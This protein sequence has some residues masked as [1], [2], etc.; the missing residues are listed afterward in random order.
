MALHAVADITRRNAVLKRILTFVMAALAASICILWG[1]AAQAYVINDFLYGQEWM[2]GLKK[3]PA[4]NVIW[5]G[6]FI[7]S[8]VQINGHGARVVI[9]TPQGA[10]KRVAVVMPDALDL[11]HFVDVPG[12][13]YLDGISFSKMAF[14]VVP[15]SVNLPSIDTSTFPPQVQSHLPLGTISLTPGTQIRGEVDLAG[16]GALKGVLDAMGIQKTKHD[17]YAGFGPMMIFDSPQTGLDQFKKSVLDKMTATVYLPKL[18]LPGLS[19]VATV[20]NNTLQFG[21]DGGNVWMKNRGE[22][23]VTVGSETV[24]FDF[25]VNFLHDG[26]KTFV[27][28]L[29]DEAP[30]SAIELDLLKPVTVSNISVVMDNTYGFWRRLIS[31]DA[32]ING[33][34][35][36]ITYVNN[37]KD[38]KSMYV[39]A[40][41]TLTDVIGG[42]VS[43]PGLDDV[44]LDMA[45]MWSDHWMLKAKLHGHEVNVVAFKRDGDAKHTVSVQFG[46]V[47]P[48]ALIPGAESTPLKEV[49]FGGLNLLYSPRQT[50]EAARGA[51]GIPTE[52]APWLANGGPNAKIRPGL[53]LYANFHIDDGGQIASLLGHVGVTARDL[54]FDGAVSTAVFK[55][56]RTS[57]SVKKE[58]L[59]AL[60]LKIPIGVN[61][62]GLPKGV[63]FQHTYLTVKGKGGMALDIAGTLDVTVGQEKVD[64][65]FDVDVQKKNGKSIVKMTANEVP[66]SQLSI[67]L[68][69][70]FTLTDLSFEMD[71]AQGFWK[72]SLHGDAAI[73]NKTVDITYSNNQW[74]WSYL[75]VKSDLT[76]AEAFQSPGLPGLDDVTLN[77]LMFTPSFMSAELTV[78]GFSSKLTVTGTPERN[79]NH[80]IFWQPTPK[81]GAAAKIS[82]AH[83]I[84][85]ADD[86][87]LKDV[88]LTDLVVVYA[89]GGDTNVARNWLPAWVGDGLNQATGGEET[90][91]SKGINV[92]GK[93][94]AHPQGE[95]KDLLSKAGITDLSHRLSGRFSPKAF[96]PNTEA[97]KDALW[98]A[99][100]INVALPTPTIAEAKDLSFKDGRLRIRGKLPDGSR[101]LDVGISGNVTWDAGVDQHDFYV[102]ISYDKSHGDSDIKV[103]GHSDQPWSDPLGIPG[104][105]LDT[106]TFD[107]QREKQSDGSKEYII[108][109]AG[110]TDIGR[111]KR[112]TAKIGLDK[113]K[114]S[115]GVKSTEAWLEIKDNI[116]LSEM[117]GFGDVLHGDKFTL[118]ELKISP[119]GLEADST[120]NGETIDLYIF[121]VGKHGSTAN[122]G[123]T[124]ALSVKDFN[125]TDVIPGIS[126]T[127][128]KHFGFPYAAVIFSKNGINARYENMG[129]IA[130]DAFKEVFTS[131][132]E[133]L[134]IAE[135]VSFVAGFHPDN[136]GAMA[137]GVRGI[138]VHD[139][140]LIMGQ[141]QGLYGGE[142]PMIRLEGILGASGKAH[143]MPAFMS[144]AQ[145]AELDFFITL[146]ESGETFDF[147]LGLAVGLN[148]KI[149]GSPLLFD[150]KVK[151]QIMDEGFGVDVLAQMQGEWHKPFGIPFSLS[152]IGMEAGTQEDGAIKVGFTGGT[153]ISGDQFTMAG[154]AEFLPEAL[155]LPQTFAFK[156]T[157]DEIDLAFLDD[158]AFMMAQQAA[159][160]AAVRLPI[161]K[162]PTPKLKEV[163]FAFATPGSEDPDLGLVSE[164]FAMAGTFNFF[165]QDLGTAQVAIG[166]A[167][168]IKIKGSIKDFD[169]GPISAKNNSL[170]IEVSYTA[171]PKFHIDSHVDILG[172]TETVKLDFKKTGMDFD[173]AFGLGPDFQGDMNLALTGVNLSAKSPSFKNA[174]FFISGAFDAKIADFI[175]SNMKDLANDLKTDLNAKYEE[176]KKKVA[177]AKATVDS[178]NTQINH[179][180]AV[181]RAERQ[182]VERKLDA[183]QSRVDSLNGD[184]AH[185][186]SEYH[187]C[188]WYH[189]WCKPEW[190]ITIAGE[191]A[192]LYIATGVLDAV[193]SLVKHIPLD[194]DPRIWPLIAAKDTA[195][196]ALDAAEKS[197]EGLEDIDDAIASVLDKVADALGNGLNIN[198]ATFEGSLTGVIENDEPVDLG[199][200]VSLFGGRFADTFAF[201]MKD[202]AYNAE[203]LAMMGLYGLDHL[204]QHELDKLPAAMRHQLIGTLAGR[205]HDAQTAMKTELAKYQKDFTKY[206]KTAGTIQ[207]A[208][209]AAAKTFAETLLTSKVSLLDKEPPSRKL[210]GAVIEIAHSG[211]CVYDDDYK[212]LT[213]FPCEHP[214]KAGYQPYNGDSSG[215]LAKQK[216][217]T[218]TVM[219]K[220]KDS[221]YVTILMG[222]KCLALNGAF[223]TEEV[224][225][226]NGMSGFRQVLQPTGASFD[227]CQAG[228]TVQHWKIL[229]HGDRYTQI[230]NRASDLC[231]AFDSWVGAPLNG[232]V[233]FAPCTGGDTQVFRVVNE[234]PQAYYKVGTVFKHLASN[235]CLTVD[236]SLTQEQL[237]NYGTASASFKSC[238]GKPNQIFD[239]MTDYLGRRKFIHKASG[240]CLGFDWR[241]SEARVR[242]CSND[243]GMFFNPLLGPGGAA[244]QAGGWDDTGALRNACLKLSDDGMELSQCAFAPEQMFVLPTSW[245]VGAN[246]KKVQNGSGLTGS[247]NAAFTMAERKKAALTKA[248]TDRDALFKALDAQADEMDRGVPGCLSPGKDCYVKRKPPQ[249]GSPVYD[250]FW[251]KDWRGNNAFYYADPAIK[252]HSDIS[253]ELKALADDLT[254]DRL[255]QVQ[256][257]G[258]GNLKKEPKWYVCRTGVWRG[259]QSWLEGSSNIRVGYVDNRKCVVMDEDSLGVMTYQRADEY[260]VLASGGGLQWIRSG[261]GY[262][263]E[264]ALQLGEIHSQ[265]WGGANTFVYSC[266]ALVNRKTVLGFTVDGKACWTK[267]PFGFGSSSDMSAMPNFEVLSVD[268]SVKLPP[269]PAPPKP[270]LPPGQSLQPGETEKEVCKVNGWFGKKCKECVMTQWGA[271]DYCWSKDDPNNYSMGE[272]GW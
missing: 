31:G 125:I 144:F 162:I 192:A 10:P 111:H 251:T 149:T 204:I 64:F 18:S 80:L 105:T 116:D 108:K 57:A 52:V 233:S 201:K 44:E 132:G 42:G 212:G 82:P 8:R 191:K 14:I 156:A 167:T 214:H 231:L 60:D 175:D 256:K 140:L 15:P 228:N 262:L 154:D 222:G 158:V 104:F 189:P 218:G 68:L 16:N 163:M 229:D 271:Y 75:D 173:V 138:G 194:F 98:D 188:H 142:T 199:L 4:T 161:D 249:S 40:K 210:N 126:S 2:P 3:L 265:N 245:N 202:M 117:P 71:N 145:S 76:L 143:N 28:L 224:S 12:G 198:Q 169:M 102:D 89:M 155:F 207:N 253:D 220:K 88:D 153:T 61:L 179:E 225:F 112:L 72:R 120:F 186:W 30:G 236:Q 119:H 164:G 190:G 241:E 221:G 130:Q 127:P 157:A 47:S 77:E 230:I 196:A 97:I 159:G 184:I 95:M 170:D 176:G 151:M 223:K 124:M 227:S 171:L 26:G 100:D 215:A 150:A 6:S 51:N 181:V 62:P 43:L 54:P 219:E 69:Q 23:D 122:S 263:P 93:L 148:V 1:G 266:R 238:T 213:Q 259:A 115:M 160:V 252:G 33:K 152:N 58:I 182:K 166:P 56:N 96:S 141:L 63:N 66:G 39:N 38:G 9:F 48:A 197:I 87:P 129:A 137:D 7:E 79:G 165:D 203:Q 187:S 264:T 106:L 260:E 131:P 91:L 85:G 121:K 146:L 78:K 135:G 235:T 123:W 234:T 109:V 239:F 73:K 209:T 128:L 65:D 20:K 172:A 19:E 205:I 217:T 208:Y 180:R 84:P 200:D 268:V 24:P 41:M 272:F 247:W 5:G 237:N 92:F 246:W 232:Q 32:N 206:Q 110:K 25:Q 118:T 226:A 270:A 86:T 45:Q 22:M 267:S 49:N 34:P 243:E 168:G 13:S 139:R 134:K 53:N 183:A 185:A 90:H 17:F 36:N 11:G 83:L 70:P 211:L 113:A 94:E 55:K 242:A 50:T 147:E 244:Y 177:E 261:G 216:V 21:A 254:P 248:A 107:M 240:G 46:G 178:L 59:D 27:Q 74:G 255:K 67:Y 114:N 250:F 258:D 133:T 81:K 136:A 269:P 193:K 195:V 103:T 37:V 35:V 29:A 99:L 174:D 101:G 257:N